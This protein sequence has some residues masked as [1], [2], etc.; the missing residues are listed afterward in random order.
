MTDKSFDEYDALLKR[1]WKLEKTNNTF[2]P[3]L[4]DTQKGQALYA[5]C[6]LQA[7][8]CR[9]QGSDVPEFFGSGRLQKLANE[10]SDKPEIGWH[11]DYINLLKGEDDDE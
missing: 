1:M 9:L 5:T 3:F 6:S 8:K 2:L 11:P 10:P 7:I 4:D